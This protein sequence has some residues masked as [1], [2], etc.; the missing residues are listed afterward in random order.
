MSAMRVM[1]GTRDIKAV[2]V[3]ALVTLAG[4]GLAL[5]GCGSGEKDGPEV[6]WAG[7]VCSHVGDG[8]QNLK[9]PASQGK[10]PEEVKEGALQ[11]LDALSGEL[12]RL[13]KGIKKEGKPPVSGGEATYLRVLKTLGNTRGAVAD[14]SETLRRAKVEDTASLQKA[15]AKA[16]KA[17]ADFNAYEGPAKD[18]KSNPELSPAFEKADSCKKIEGVGAD[19]AAARDH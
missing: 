2:R 14:A 5:A 9:L 6:A 13:G 16:G 7:R 11:F 19:A 3:L 8:A 4:T 12:S 15:L 18:F 10:K 17:M 1:K